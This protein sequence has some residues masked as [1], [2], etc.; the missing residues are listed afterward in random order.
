MTDFLTDEPE[1][2][3][4]S[5]KGLETVSPGESRGGG[6]KD[7]KKVGILVVL[8]VVGGGVVAYQLTRGGG[9]K[10][11][12]AVTAAG[13]PGGAASS[14]AEVESVLARL[15][16]GPAAE[17]DELSVERVEALVKRF[18]TYV[19][20]RQVPLALLQANPFE[21]TVSPDTQEQI[22][23][24]AKAVVDEKARQREEQ[25]KQVQQEALAK[26]QRRD[27]L[28]RLKVGSILITDSQ[29]LAL[30]D[31]KIRRVGD[32]VQGFRLEAIEPDRVTLS[33]D[34]ETADLC[35]RPVSETTRGQ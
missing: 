11:A 35:L 9:P 25:E 28:S 15:D 1:G 29:R 17:G 4:V 23:T 33:F 16:A 18:D 34:G 3:R 24:A 14:V 27:A 13:A 12:A 8:L 30:V 21:V 10:T 26:Q 19:Q 7:A 6:F 22:A 2:V 32:E 5:P 20:E 31:G